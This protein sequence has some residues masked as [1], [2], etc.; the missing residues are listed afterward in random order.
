MVKN[1]DKT[2]IVNDQNQEIDTAF[3]NSLVRNNAK[4]RHDRAEVIA[5]D[6]FVTYKR[7]VEDI[8]LKIKKLIRERDNMLDLS[9]DT[10]LSLIVASDFDAKA[11]TEKDI[12]LG[13]KI[14]N[15]EIKLEIAQKRFN[16]LF[17]GDV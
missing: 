11:F 14:R 13:I 10:A 12:E 9:P 16:W 4:I 6:A 3:M 7:A 15:E 2:I 8:Q 5:E 1:N 17:G